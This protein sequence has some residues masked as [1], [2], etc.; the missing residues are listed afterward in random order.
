MTFSPNPTSGPINNWIKRIGLWRDGSVPIDHISDE[1]TFMIKTSMFDGLCTIVTIGVHQS[2][3]IIETIES[4]I[5]NTSSYRKEVKPTKHGEYVCSFEVFGGLFCKGASFE[6][7]A[8][9]KI[10]ISEVFLELLNKHR[11]K[12]VFSSDLRLKP[13]SLWIRCFV[14]AS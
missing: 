8:C 9:A 1:N 10:L 3:E 14:N 2:S 7:A 4:S 5:G 13:V 6:S 11:F 12:P